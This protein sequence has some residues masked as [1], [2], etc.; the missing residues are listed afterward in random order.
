MVS[1]NK[2][3]CQIKDTRPY[4]LEILKE[5][6][7]Y[8]RLDLYKQLYKNVVPIARPLVDFHIRKTQKKLDEQPEQNDLPF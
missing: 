8:K 4:M 5:Q 3:L 7:L 2:A 6:N 1:D